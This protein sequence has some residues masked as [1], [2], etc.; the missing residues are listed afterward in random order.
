[1]RILI[2]KDSVLYEMNALWF[3][4][5]NERYGYWH[6]LTDEETVEWESGQRCK[7]ANCPADIFED[8]TDPKF[9]ID[10]KPIAGSVDITRQW[11][12]DGHEVGVIT[13][14]AN[15]IAAKPSMDWLGIYYPHIEN[16]ILTSAGIKYWVVGDILID[17]AI[18]NHIGFQGIS[19][20]YGQPWNKRNTKFIRARDWNHVNLIV[21]RAERYIDHY[22]DLADENAHELWAHKWIE[23]RLK[24]EVDEGL[25]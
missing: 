17:D 19:I 24:V 14:A 9:W 10:G 25:L 21:A 13:N 5:H 23:A 20:V 1:M 16:V 2:D 15:S 3:G 12:K 7:A 18:H 6:I 22:A 4:R 8:F 11:V